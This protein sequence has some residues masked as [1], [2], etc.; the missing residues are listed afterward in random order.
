[1]GFYLYIQFYM[2]VE[3]VVM[4]WGQVTLCAP[5]SSLVKEDWY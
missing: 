3:N 1:M 4:A 2:S 5:E